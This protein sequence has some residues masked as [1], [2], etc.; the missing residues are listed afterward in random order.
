[1]NPFRPPADAWSRRDFMRNSMG[2]FALLCTLGAPGTLGGKK[3]V[4]SA[5]RRAQ[6]SSPFTPFQRDLPLMPVLSPVRSARL[7]HGRYTVELRARDATGNSSSLL[8]S[9]L[10]IRRK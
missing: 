8:R 2:S 4:T 3:V 1:M 7:T 6:A 9:D 10:R 5:A